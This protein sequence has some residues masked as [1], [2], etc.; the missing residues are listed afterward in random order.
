MKLKIFNVIGTPSTGGIQ[1]HILDLSIYDK[2]YE[3][4]RSVVCI[5]GMSKKESQKFI[6][7]GINCLP[8]MIMPKYRGWRPH[9]FW[10][11]LR[12]IF[13]IFFIFKY[14]KLFKIHQPDI[15]VCENSSY[16]N[17]QLL[18]AR[19]LKIRF[20]WYMHNPRQLVDV[21]K[22]LLRLFLKNYLNNNLFIMASSKIVLEKNLNSFKK[23]IGKK[24]KKYPI[25]PSLTCIEKILT[26]NRYRNFNNNDTINIGSI[27]RLTWEKNFE[28]LIRVFARLR[29]I[30]DK[31]LFLYI[32][33]D[34]PTKKELTD[35][36]KKLD[37]DNFVILLGNIDRL[38][39]RS[40]LSKINIYVQSSKSEGS[41]NT[42]KE[43]M[44]AA[45]PVVTT[46]V[47]GIS[48]MINHEKTGLL[49]GSENVNDLTSSLVRLINEKIDYRQSIGISAQKHAKNN[50]SIKSY[51]EKH[52][53]I[54]Q[55]LLNMFALYILNEFSFF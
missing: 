17:A 6:S 47:G 35:L 8:C 29:K 9:R 14:Y 1:T 40:L 20:I 12:N 37:I 51:A 16:L 38:E 55:N 15:I 52:A 19:I 23:I 18:V 5:H 22:L 49:V 27:G 45:L 25:M 4:S 13:K 32:A 43:A 34:G 39:I 7:K 3:I 10:K 11:V 31:K 50:F 24:W 30:I 28:L 53:K 41:P 2:K 42:I 21:N 44:A 26:E 46:D 48:E 54:Y 33:G 36:I